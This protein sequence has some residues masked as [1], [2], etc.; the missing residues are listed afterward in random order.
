[1]RGLHD[2]QHDVSVR[3]EDLL[4]HRGDQVRNTEKVHDA[5]QCEDDLLK[6]YDA[7]LEADAVHA[8]VGLVDDVDLVPNGSQVRDEGQNYEKP[9]RSR[10]RRHLEWMARGVHTPIALSRV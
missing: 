7:D 8:G 10:V 2:L 6:H 1:M 4:G 3:V 9:S 5:V